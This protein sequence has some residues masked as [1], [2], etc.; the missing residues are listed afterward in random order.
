MIKSNS[1]NKVLEARK[2]LGLSQ[3]DLANELR[4]S[5]R[6]IQSWEQ[7]W[8]NAPDWVDVMIE[9]LLAKV[10]KNGI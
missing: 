10:R 3:Q 9:N 5:V 6:S 7:G 1:A 2:R 8:R 4:I